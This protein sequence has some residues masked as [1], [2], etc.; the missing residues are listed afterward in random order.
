MKEMPIH[1]AFI[2]ELENIL[3]NLVELKEEK[4]Q[5]KIGNIFIEYETTE[6]DITGT[7]QRDKFTI[8]RY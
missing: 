3:N 6:K 1:P 7:K 5:A 4:Y 2:I 8:Y